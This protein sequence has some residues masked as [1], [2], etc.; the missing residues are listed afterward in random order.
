MTG[1]QTCALPIYDF[2]SRSVA[3]QRR[4]LERER[5]RENAF[6]APQQKVYREVTIPETM[7]VQELAHR[8]E[9]LLDLCRS[10]RRSFGPSEV[11][12]TLKS[13][14]LLTAL[15]S[16]LRQRLAGAAGR[17]AGEAAAGTHGRKSCADA[18]TTAPQ[19]PR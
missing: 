15:I 17:R 13:V 5:R 14:D 19:S 4:R 1:V 3:Q 16:D 6:D 2:R 9:N 8:A 10:G 7:T 18:R 12:A 11:E